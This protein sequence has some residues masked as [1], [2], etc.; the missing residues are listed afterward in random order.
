VC[1]FVKLVYNNKSLA[2]FLTLQGSFSIAL[3]GNLIRTAFSSRDIN[4]RKSVS[5]PSPSIP[6]VVKKAK[7]NKPFIKTKREKGKEK[8]KK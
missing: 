7:P 3:R 1:G 2:R 6:P 4:R 5:D 8:I